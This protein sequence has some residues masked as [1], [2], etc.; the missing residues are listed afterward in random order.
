MQLLRAF[1]Y[2]RCP[3]SVEWPLRSAIVPVPR[4]GH[5]AV[6]PC[7][8]QFSLPLVL[9]LCTSMAVSRYHCPLVLELFWGSCL[10]HS[11]AL[12]TTFS[13]E[14]LCLLNA[15]ATHQVSMVFPHRCTQHHNIGCS[16]MCNCH[17]FACWFQKVRLRSGDSG[18]RKCTTVTK[19]VLL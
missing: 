18:V 1:A 17:K 8:V 12:S 2:R 13:D 16:K 14:P 7:G 6:E 9:V 10:V 11:T 5:R 4:A 15:F 3:W 19:C